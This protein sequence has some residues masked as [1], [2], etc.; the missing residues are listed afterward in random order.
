M[1]SKI[2]FLL[3]INFISFGQKIEGFFISP[4]FGLRLPIGN[5]SN[6]Y[7]T[8]FNIGANIEYANTNI[9]FLIKSE[10]KYGFLPGKD[11]NFNFHSNQSIYSASLGLN[12]FLLP[13]FSNDFLF[14][15][16]AGINVNYN[17]IELGIYSTES[18]MTKKQ[19]E[20]EFGFGASVGMTIFLMDL[21]LNYNIIKRDSYFSID[22]LIRLPIYIAY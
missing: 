4:N 8:G 16:I 19:L 6:A 1:K 10:F 9:P 13:I 22:Y 14:L 2:F 3:I 21:T 5:I 7:S 18:G 11:L 12:Y 15:T 17:Y 20:R